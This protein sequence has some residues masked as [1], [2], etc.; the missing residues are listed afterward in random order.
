M[1]I[2]GSYPPPYG[3]AS[4]HSRRLRPLLESKGIDYTIYNAA[5]DA[6]DG[7]RVISVRR[8]RF[9]RLLKYLFTA[10]ESAFYIMS[11]RLLAWFAG[12]WLIQVRGKR[13]WIRLRNEQLIVWEKTSPLKCALAGFVLRRVHGVVCVSRALAQTASRFGVKE[14]RILYTPGF[15]PPV[16]DEM[17]L[18][19]TDPS[20]VHF[21]DNHSPLLVANGKVRQY[22]GN[23]LYGLDHMVELII[24]I[25]PKYQNIGLLVCLSDNEPRTEDYVAK[26]NQHAVEGN[27]EKNIYFTSN[28]GPMTPYL[29]R[30]DL[31]LRPTTTDGDAVS[32]RESLYFDI[33]VVASDAVQR[34]AGVTCFPTRD[35]DAF[36]N[37]VH[38][39]LG[40][41]SSSSE[42]DLTPSISQKK[43]VDDRTELYLNK[44]A[45]FVGS[46]GES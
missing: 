13:V 25:A 34:P 7:K 8:N 33:P 30:A 22:N 24:R 17:H 14:N 31:F 20:L 44:L 36:E 43:E 46:S 2:F 16:I 18:S 38:L 27:V 9:W 3:G 12:L 23:D 10:D 39:V 1:A 6:A 28:P 45:Q 41:V 26:L 4:M 40:R 42:Q 29:A 32:I 11:P 5:S 19:S 21:A 35:L 37:S 15:L